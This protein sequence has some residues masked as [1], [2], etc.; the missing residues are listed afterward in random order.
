[1]IVLSLTGI[2]YNV[3]YKRNKGERL[4]MNQEA[5]TNI[6][7]KEKNNAFLDYFGFK[8]LN[9]FYKKISEYAQNHFEKFSALVVA[10]TTLGIWII[11]AFGYAYQSG[12]LSVYN[13]DKSYISLDDN[14]LLQIV[15]FIAV[16]VLFIV[17]N[18]FYFYI[19]TKEDNSRFHLKRKWRKI[20]L[21]VTEILIILV[22]IILK[23]NYNINSFF[24][25]LQSYSIAM[26][27]TLIILLLVLVLMF[28]IFGIEIVHTKYKKSKSDTANPSA[29]SQKTNNE[30][31]LIKTIVVFLAVLMADSYIWGLLGERQRTNYKIIAE[32]TEEPITNPTVFTFQDN[33]SSF[34]YAIV[35]E[36][37]D[38]YILCQL[39][40][41]DNE[42]TIDK[43]YQRI[44]PKDNLVT[45]SVDNIY[46]IQFME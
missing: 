8:T 17:I 3:I 46:K 16:G 19:A 34:L 20:K 29:E 26:W 7:T 23:S 21:Y 30:F 39:Q 32:Q 38:V 15:E 45:Y 5:N 24:K 13:I 10:T 44:V 31:L 28:N 11:R 43:N 2:I 9:K 35:Y 6:E 12:K 37:Q 42:I 25:E 41:L 14:F 18:Y 27:I 4:L 36:N 40:K 22:F 1:M 33:T